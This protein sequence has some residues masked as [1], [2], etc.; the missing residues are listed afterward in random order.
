MA[1]R[2]HETGTRFCVLIWSPNF[3][4]IL[5][6]FIN[7]TSCLAK[8]PYESAIPLEERKIKHIYFIALPIIMA[9]TTYGVCLIV[10]SD[11]HLSLYALMQALEKLGC[12]T[13]I[14]SMIHASFYI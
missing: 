12:G 6:R 7:L 1:T 10:M 14:D 4:R 8:F 2:T 5:E 11:T 9:N 13:K 3:G